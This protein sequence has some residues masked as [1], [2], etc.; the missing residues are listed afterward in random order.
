MLQEQAN[1]NKKLPLD[2]CLED[3]VA[4]LA[5]DHSEAIIEIDGKFFVKKSAISVWP[6]GLFNCN[7]KRGIT[8]LN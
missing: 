3:Y 7:R 5:R 2:K 6:H 8:F 4:E 1:L